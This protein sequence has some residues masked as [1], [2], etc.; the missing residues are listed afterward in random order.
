MTSLKGHFLIAARELLDPNF[1]ASVV[2][3][4]QHSP[5][6]AMGLVVNHPS[7]TTVADAWEQIAHED[8]P[9]RDRIHVGGPCEGTLSVIHTQAELADLEVLPALFFTA[10]RSSVEQL[11]ASG[12]N[13][14]RFFVGYSGWGP[15]QLEREIVHGGWLM[16]PA[17]KDLVFARDQKLWEAMLK[18]S[19]GQAV[20]ASLGI[21]HVP[22]DAE[23]N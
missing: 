4:V 7:D 10:D 19:V 6:G 16:L 3:I 9:I 1:R 11:V 21:K 20:I 23:L 5:E 8:C 12:S 22:G 2:L 18:R 15:G 14:L 13:E 17:T